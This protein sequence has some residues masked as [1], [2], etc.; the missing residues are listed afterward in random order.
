[1]GFCRKKASIR[2]DKNSLTNQFISDNIFCW[3]GTVSIHHQR[4]VSSIYRKSLRI[5]T[6]LKGKHTLFRLPL[7]YCAEIIK[8][9]PPDSE[10]HVCFPKKAEEALHLNCDIVIV[11]AGPAG[12]FTALELVRKKSRKNPDGRKGE[13]CAGTPLP[14]KCD[15]AVC[16]L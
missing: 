14:Q 16:K 6:P 3:V 2:Y 10:K 8:T 12:I 7:F 11:G 4:N 1:M 9:A 5:S 15:R 13:P